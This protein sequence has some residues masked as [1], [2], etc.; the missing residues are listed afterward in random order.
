MHFY[1]VGVGDR[2]KAYYWSKYKVSTRTI[3]QQN[4]GVHWLAELG[5][6]AWVGVIIII[7]ILN[8][9]F[10]VCLSLFKCGYSTL[11]THHI[12]NT[13]VTASLHKPHQ[14]SFMKS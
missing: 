8:N 12:L 9:S 7:I 13:D 2:E 14:V 4:N 11:E 5:H 10:A 1:P 3:I 6:V